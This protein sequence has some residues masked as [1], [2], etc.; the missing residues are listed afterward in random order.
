MDSDRTDKPKEPYMKPALV[1]EDELEAL[2]STC[3]D[4]DLGSGAKAS[5]VS[6]CNVPGSETIPCTAN[7]NS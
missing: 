1:F 3:A 2:A 5:A 4:C 7:F 6:F